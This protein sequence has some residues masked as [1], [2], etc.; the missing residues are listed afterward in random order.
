M[1]LWVIWIKH[2]NSYVFNQEPLVPVET[3]IWSYIL[4]YA[5]IVWR[6]VLNSIREVLAARLPILSL[7]N[8]AVC[9]V[10][11]RGF[12]LTYVY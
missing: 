9:R 11:V 2:I 6:R 1:I 7:K 5:K 12:P 4:E 10:S 3:T 8:L